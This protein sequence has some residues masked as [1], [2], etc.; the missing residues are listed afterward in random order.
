MPS[1]GA[2]GAGLA[3]WAP[4]LQAAVLWGSLPRTPAQG[5]PG[6][7]RPLLSPC[8]RTAIALQGPGLPVLQQDEVR[9]D[10]PSCPLAPQSPLHGVAGKCEKTWKQ[11][12]RVR[13]T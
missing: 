4:V 9:A 8:R 2:E 6:P 7:A 13:D 3:D 11:E 12:A 1:R 5:L 10:K